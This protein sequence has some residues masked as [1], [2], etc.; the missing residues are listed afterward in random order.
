[1][2][3]TNCL[4][5]TVATSEGFPGLTIGEQTGG[6]WKAMAG[7]EHNLVKYP[8]VKEETKTKQIW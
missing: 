7:K 1:M 6:M 3:S 4:E 2:V 8:R 5:T